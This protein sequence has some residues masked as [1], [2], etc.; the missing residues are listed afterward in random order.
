MMSI[1]TS[2]DIRLID[3]YDNGLTTTGIL[4]LLFSTSQWRHVIAMAF[5]ITDNSI[6]G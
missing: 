3:L 1:S 5:Q 2:L 6:I 4:L